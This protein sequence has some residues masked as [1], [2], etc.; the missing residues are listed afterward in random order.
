MAPEAFDS[1][2]KGGG[3]VRTKEM[4][5]GR[6]AHIC[7]PKSGPSVMG[8][9]KTKQQKGGPQGRVYERGKPT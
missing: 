9:V 3:R 6:Y 7:I 1:C 5:R 2:V 8:E 4:S